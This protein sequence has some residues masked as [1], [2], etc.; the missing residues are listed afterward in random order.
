MFQL[1]DCKAVLFFNWGW[2][3]T[4]GTPAEGSHLISIVGPM[5]SSILYLSLPAVNLYPMSWLFCGLFR[6]LCWRDI[7]RD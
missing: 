2:S 7:S 6:H 3:A 4:Q 5:P 1:Q